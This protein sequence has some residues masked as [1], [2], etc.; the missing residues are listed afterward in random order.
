MF[1]LTA[2]VFIVNSALS[3]PRGTLT[4][5]GTITDLEDELNFT[6]SAP[7]PGPGSALSVTWP[8][9]LVPPF[10]EDGLTLRLMISNGVSVS[11]AVWV[12]PAYLAVIVT[13]S[14]LVTGLC[15]TVK[16][17]LELPAATFTEAGTLASF[18]FELVSV[19]VSPGEAARP[20]KLTVPTTAVLEPPTTVLGKSET[21]SRPAGW[22]ASGALWDPTLEVPAIVAVTAVVT[23]LVDTAN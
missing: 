23:A 17:M 11:V 12:S 5:A 6:A 21:F 3:S 20:L 22:I 9:A 18:V 19:T 13:D 4:V 14:V 7:L 10:T 1:E 8:L 15:V 2:S 16:L